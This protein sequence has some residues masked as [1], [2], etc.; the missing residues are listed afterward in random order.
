[1]IDSLAIT[2]G[3]NYLISPNKTIFSIVGY[4][5]KG[6]NNEG[7]NAVGASSIMHILN[8]TFSQ[9]V[10]RHFLEQLFKVETMMWH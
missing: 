8:L 2:I 1:M 4:F 10:S 9:Y 5:T 7:S 6:I 3:F